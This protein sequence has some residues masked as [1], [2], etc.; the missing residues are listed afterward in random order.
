MIYIYTALTSSISYSS[1]GDGQE[2][3]KPLE[4]GIKLMFGKPSMMIVLSI[5]TIAV[6]TRDSGVYGFLVS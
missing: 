5:D 4:R 2:S 6:I 3:P 1:T